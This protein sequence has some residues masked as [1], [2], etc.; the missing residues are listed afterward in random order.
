MKKLFGL[1]LVTILFSGCKDDQEDQNVYASSGETAHWV[2][3]FPAVAEGA[4]TADL[5]FQLQEQG[6]IHYIVSDVPLNLTPQQLIKES[7]SPSFEQIRE[8]GSINARKSDV[9]VATVDQ[10][11]EHTRY[12][13]YALAGSGSSNDSIHEISF[14]TKVRQDTA[15]FKSRYEDREVNYLLYLPEEV[16]KYPEKKDYPIIF[17][18][19]GHGEAAT[20]RKPINV[21]QNGLLPEYIYKGNDV[22]TMVMTIQHVNKEWKNELINEAMDFAMQHLPVDKSRV[23]LVG[24]SAG[25][26]GVWR[27]AQAFPERLTAI[28]AASGGGDTENICRLKEIPVR[29]FHNQR[30]HLVPPG[31]SMKMVDAVNNCDPRIVARLDIFPDS[32]HNCW[33]RVFDPNHPDWTKSPDM[34]RIDIYGWLLQHSRATAN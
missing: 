18:L 6:T 23:Y 20:G 17:F 24:T 29:A 26:F 25:A 27:F 28:V 13:A 11:R 3:G 1:L 31:Q 32:G 33:R 21:I 12:Y 10:L 5:T 16:L 7:T 19:G 22:P 4:T 8:N 15:S 34:N 9:T 2:D 30:D 14:V